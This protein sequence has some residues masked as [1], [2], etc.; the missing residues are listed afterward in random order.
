MPANSNI[1][2][3]LGIDVG[4]L[5]G[6]EKR[7]ERQD[8]SRAVLHQRLDDVVLRMTHVEVDVTSLRNRTDAMEEV[9]NQVET[10]RQRAIGAGTLG[11]WMLA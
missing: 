6:I 4:K 9:T 10:M 1:E 11:R 5:E 2:R 3:A 7:L 8:E